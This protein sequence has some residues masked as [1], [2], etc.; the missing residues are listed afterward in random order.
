MNK[1]IIQFGIAI[2]TLSTAACIISTSGAMQKWVGQGENDLVSKWGAP[3][4]SAS[5]PNGNKVLTWITTYNDAADGKPSVMVQCKTS[6]TLSPTGK[7][8]SF[9]YVQC[10]KYIPASMS[11]PPV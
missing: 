6:F 10:P 11:R 8:T 9:S 7:V 3:D 5:L 1:R 2:I 4:L